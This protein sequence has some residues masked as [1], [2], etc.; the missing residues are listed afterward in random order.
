MNVRVRIPT[1]LR[2]LAA[3]AGSVAANESSTELT[4]TGVESTT[5]TTELAPA[6]RFRS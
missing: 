6:A 5:T 1:Q 3:G 2:N 4:V